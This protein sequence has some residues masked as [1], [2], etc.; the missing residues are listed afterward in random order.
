MY[1]S[2]SCMLIFFQKS[3]RLRFK[4]VSVLDR[5]SLWSRLQGIC[6]TA[7]PVCFFLNKEKLLEYYLTSACANVL[8]SSQFSGVFTIQ[9]TDAVHKL[10]SFQYQIPLFRSYLQ[11]LDYL[12]I[13]YNIGNRQ[14]LA[15][16]FHFQQ[17]LEKGL[18][19]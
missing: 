3:P 9:V 11:T 12:S 5:I 14:R 15:T 1:A 13:L 16:L 18:L 4:D 17:V 2:S 10:R 7:K 19:K 6:H 8:Q